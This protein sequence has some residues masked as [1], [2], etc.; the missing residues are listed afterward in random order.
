MIFVCDLS[1]HLVECFYSN[2]LSKDP[3]WFSVDNI[4]PR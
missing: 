4:I 2:G 1:S 3:F